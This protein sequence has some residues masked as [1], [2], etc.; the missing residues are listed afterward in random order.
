MQKFSWNCKGKLVSF[1]APIVM[2]ILNITP[3]SFYDGGVY[4]SEKEILHQVEKYIN[5]GANI[6]DIGGASSRPNADLISVEEELKRVEKIINLIHQNFPEIL[7]SIDTIHCKVAEVAISNG[8]SIIND[9]TGT[10][11]DIKIADV[12]KKY[13]CPL[14]IMHTQ[15]SFQTMHQA[16]TYNNMLTDIYDFFV[17]KIRYIEEIGIK[18]VVIDVGFGFS[19]TIEQNYEL[20]KNLNFYTT[21]DKPILAGMSRKSMLYKFLGIEPSTSLN[22]TSIVNTIALQQGASILRVHDVK[23]AME[24]IKIYQQLQKQ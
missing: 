23:E 5:E 8:V 7:L 21:L 11:H 14:I 12:A 10:N 2:A 3:D 13:A 6:I 18:D 22:A 1:D 20:L 19:K 17:Q 16:T 9:I 24:C 4:S 15:G